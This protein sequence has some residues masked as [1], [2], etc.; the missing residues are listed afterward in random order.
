MLNKAVLTK[1]GETVAFSLWL[2]RDG[3][4]VEVGGVRGALSGLPLALKPRSRFRVDRED[5]I[6]REVPGVVLKQYLPDVEVTQA[7]AKWSVGKAGKITYKGGVVDDTMAGDN[8]S[9]ESTSGLSSWP[10][11]CLAYADRDSM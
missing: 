11:N 1:K 7:G 10:R 8:P 5:G 6:W 2:S 9:M 3:V 4:S